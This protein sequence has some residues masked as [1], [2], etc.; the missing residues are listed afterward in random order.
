MLNIVRSTLGTITSMRPLLLPLVAI[1]VGTAGAAGCGDSCVDMTGPSAIVQAAARYQIDVYGA[2][3]ACNG[4]QAAGGA[5]APESRTFVA[6]AHL[7]IDLPS[8]QHTIVLTAFDAANDPLGS[9]CHE[10]SFG[11]ATRICLSLQLAPPPDLAVCGGGPCPCVVDGDCAPD[12]Y[13]AP[14]GLCQ[15]GC[16]SNDDCVAAGSDGGG[17][18]VSLPLCDTGPHVCVGCRNAA[19]CVRTP[20]CQGNV[21]VSYPANGSPCVNGACLYP[22]PTIVSCMFG[23]F[24]GVC[25]GQ[26]ASLINVWALQT[27]TQTTVALG[28]V[29]G[30]ESGGG[31]APATRDVTVVASTTPAGAAHTLV[32]TYM[33]NGNFAAQT[34]VS[35]TR[36]GIVTN[37]AEEWSGTVPKQP[38]GTRVYFF[39][40]A[41]GWDGTA[42]F[43][44]G[45]QRNYAYS[46]N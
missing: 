36:T 12:R 8:G 32:L 24:G 7:T 29:L 5:P 21:Q 13:C 1:A 37:G 31:S 6:G 42:L 14:T 45:S 19:D 33:L 43:A 26:L 22:P 23:C 46:S 41:T 27:G 10:G 34:Q 30:T 4:G 2:G 35:M 9:A 3:V 28:T 16:R 40:D 44:P 18:T 39:L 11:A 17:Q 25:S 38:A 20:D 15:L